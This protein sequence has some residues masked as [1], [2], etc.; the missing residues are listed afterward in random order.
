MMCQGYRSP[1]KSYS[2]GPFFGPS[3]EAQSIAEPRMCRPRA[4]GHEVIR[5]RKSLESFDAVVSV[6]W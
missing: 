5:A 4:Q 2:Q 3:D 6:A 1:S